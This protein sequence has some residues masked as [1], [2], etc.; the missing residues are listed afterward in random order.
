MNEIN[1]EAINQLFLR[2]NTILEKRSKEMVEN[3]K[4]K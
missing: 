3:L 1:N 4:S 2:R